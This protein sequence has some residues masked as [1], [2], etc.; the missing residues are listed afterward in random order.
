[1]SRETFIW[2]KE[3]KKFI[4]YEKPKK[5]EVHNVIG[6]E[7]SPLLHP[8]T[9]EVVTS[10]RLFRAKT[11]IHGGLEI[12]TER[13]PDPDKRVYVQN[14]DRKQRVIEAY[15]IEKENAWRR[16]NGGKPVDRPWNDR[17]D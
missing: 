14:G 5:T 12:G 3:Q 2:D 11:R 10:K 8:M 7:M 1:M 13:L 6:D 4:P 17:R 15:Q 16:R 9:N